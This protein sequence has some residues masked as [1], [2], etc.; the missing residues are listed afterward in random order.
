MTK[1]SNTCDTHGYAI[2]ELYLG[3]MSKDGAFHDLLRHTP[4]QEQTATFSSSIDP[5]H[6]ADSPVNTKEA[7]VG[8]DLFYQSG[9]TRGLPAIM[10]VALL[11]ETP[12]NA[13]AEIRYLENHKYPISYIEIGEEADG[14]YMLPEDY[15][16]LYLQFATAL[17]QD[18]PNLKLGGPSFQGVNDD[19]EVWPDAD[20]RTPPG[21][22]ASCSTCASTIACR[23]F[24]S[25]PS[26][27]IPMSLAT[28]PGPASM[29]R[30][31]SSITSS[32]YGIMTATRFRPLLH[33]RVESV[34]IHQ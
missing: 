11:Y 25:S 19:I 20:G 2:K 18:D 21:W 14:Q 28:L 7:Q 17:R 1:S 24:S 5:W 34:L 30:R 10:P 15:G 33:H 6:T 31:N 32:T 9:V 3:A 16:A 4:D 23:I 26:S 29:M 13:V 12:D 8:F 27:T 22:A